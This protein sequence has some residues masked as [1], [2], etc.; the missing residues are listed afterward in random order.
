MAKEMTLKISKE[1]AGK[2][3]KSDVE[4]ISGVNINICLQCRKCTNGCPVSEF[5]ESGPA[6]IIKRLQLGAGIDIL[7]NSIIWNCASCE[8]C[9]GRCPMGIDMAA[10]MDSLRILSVEKGAKKPPANMPFVNKVLLKTVE[11]FGR[12]YDLGL[13]ALYKVRT[14][15][16]M[17]DTS[18]FPMILRKGKIGLLPPMGADRKSVKKIF[19][20]YSSGKDKQ[21]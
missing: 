14:S 12:T 3:I 11:Y 17:R 18:K 9:Y 1:N 21:K 7:N 5:S 15:T 19:K 4:R 16:Y 8:T 10:V 6:E 2:G 20:T 13:M